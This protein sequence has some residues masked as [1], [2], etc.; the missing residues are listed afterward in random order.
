[1]GY[2]LTAVIFF[3]VLLHLIK[4][5]HTAG[6]LTS[7]RYTLLIVSAVFASL[8]WPAVVA[9]ACFSL[10]W[11]ALIYLLKVYIFK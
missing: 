2:L 9:L 10:P 6:E 11:I 8:M 3:L 1:M 5:K 7:G 4:K